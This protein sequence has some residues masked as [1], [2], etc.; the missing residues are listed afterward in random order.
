MGQEMRTQAHLPVHTAPLTWSYTDVV[1]Q[2]LESG[3]PTA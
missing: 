1:N 2:S 3:G